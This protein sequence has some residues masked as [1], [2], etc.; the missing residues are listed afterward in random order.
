MNLEVTVTVAVKVNR[1]CDRDG[2]TGTVTRTSV[3]GNEVAYHDQSVTGLPEAK[4]AP[5]QPESIPGRRQ[6]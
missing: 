6:S 2:V 5:S 4:A 1:D 3:T